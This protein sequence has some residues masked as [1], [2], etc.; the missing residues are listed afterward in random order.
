M[1]FTCGDVRMSQSQSEAKIFANSVK[2]I[3]L[4]Q[5]AVQM[6]YHTKHSQVKGLGHFIAEQYNRT[7]G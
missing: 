2:I 6:R 1:T 3:V 4:L 7:R 5:F